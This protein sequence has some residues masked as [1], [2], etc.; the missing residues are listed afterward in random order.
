MAS[1]RIMT[2]APFRLSNILPFDV[3]SSHELLKLIPLT[4]TTLDRAEPIRLN[5]TNVI[6]YQ[7]KM[8]KEYEGQDPIAIAKKA[9]QDLN[10]QANSGKPS[11]STKVCSSSFQRLMVLS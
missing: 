7:L 6:P 1:L 11:D 8:S 2:T 5:N 9:E 3:R 10:S 4:G